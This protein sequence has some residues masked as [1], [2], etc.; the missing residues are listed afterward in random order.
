M[1]ILFHA[2]TLNFRGTTVAVTDYAKY[3]QEILGNDSVIVYNESQGYEKDMGTEAVVLHNLRKQFNIISYKEGGLQK[4]IDRERVDLAYFIRAGNKEPLPNNVKTAVHSV[5]QF[6]EPHGDIYAYVSE[7]L[8][9]TMPGNHPYVPHIVNLP[10]PN[11]E[12]RKQFGISDEQIVIGRYGGFGTFDIPFVKQAI[13]RLVIKDKRFVFLFLGTDPFIS[14]KNVRY[15]TE[16]QDLQ[17]KANFINT[18]DAMIHARQ[19][20]ESFGLS[21]AE[22]L[23]LNKPVLAWEGGHD[24]NHLEM[25]KDSGLLYN[26]SNLVDK[27]LNIKELNNQDWSQRTEMYKPEVVMNKFKDVFLS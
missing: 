6:H 4:I 2:N 16:N 7:W 18:C 11:S 21:I 20:G 3:N 8:A 12:Y 10:K 5:F 23:S 22:F 14:N 27:L 1:K 26:E 13:E 9:K 25:L 24:L 17:K 19:R 15:I